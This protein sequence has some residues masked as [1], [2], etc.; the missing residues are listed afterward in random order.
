MCGNLPSASQETLDRQVESLAAEARGLLLELLQYQSLAGREHQVQ[1]YLHGWLSRLGLD[2]QLLPQPADISRDPN[3]SPHAESANP[4]PNLKVILK[5]KGGG[6]S[7]L[8]NS[9]T[10]VVPANDP[11]QYAPREEA[12]RVIG[13]GACDAKGQVV[14]WILAL[15]AVKEAGIALYGDCVGS[16][17][18]EE[19]VGG[20][21][22][23]AWVLTQ[24]AQDLALVLEPTDLKIHPANRGAVWF[25]IATTGTSTHM[26]RWWEG[27]SAYERLEVLLQAARKWDAELVLQS[28]GVPLFPDNPSPAHVNIGMVRAGDWPATV[29]A[30]AVAEGGISFLPN[31]T[32]EQI[33]SDFTQAITQAAQLEGI[34]ASVTFERLQNQAYSIPADHP[35][36]VTL[37]NCLKQ[38]AGASEVTGFLASCDARLFYHRGKM[39]TIVFGPGSLQ[40]AHS[41]N[42]QIAVQDVVTAARALARFIVQWCGAD[43]VET[44][45]EG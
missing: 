40:H 7:L 17:V 3:Y 26:G 21:G 14:T 1:E 15:L 45:Q 37:D 8:L 10:D 42:E 44:G 25:K 18:V 13:R 34:P 4:A 20:N 24:P 27:I 16:A 29:P 28:R 11:S 2:T 38:A 35:G 9:H 32:L 5:G 19:E 41:Q 22:A 30:E 23:L 31:K 36:V 12:G 6:R 33:K 43:G 39:P